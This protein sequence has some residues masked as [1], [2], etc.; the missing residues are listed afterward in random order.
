MSYTVWSLGN[1]QHSPSCLPL[2]PL[3]KRWPSHWSLY[4]T[5]TPPL[6]LCSCHPLCPG[7]WSWDLLTVASIS[8]ISTERASLVIVSSGFPITPYSCPCYTLV[9]LTLRSLVPSWLRWALSV[10]R[11][12]GPSRQH[13]GSSVVAACR[14]SCP[15][16]CEISVH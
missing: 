5:L 10:S 9:T 1:F 12:D 13:A 15:A 6:G 2:I 7:R 8:D 3:C 11:V 14:L 4:T 16:T